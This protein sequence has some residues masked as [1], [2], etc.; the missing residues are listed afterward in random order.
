MKR[1]I[2]VGATSGIGRELA[3][4][5]SQNG[6][7][8]GLTGRREHLLVSLQSELPGPSY[9]QRTDISQPSESIEQL[10]GLAVQ[11]GGL[12]L[13]IISAG[14]GVINSDLAWDGERDKINVNVSGFTAVASFGIRYFI[15]QGVGHL[16]AI[17]SVAAL[18][19]SGAAPAYNASKAFVSNYA[20]GLRQKV[21]KLKL[22]IIITDV[23]PGFVDTAMAKGEGL[24][25]VASPEKAAQ[26]I[27]NAICRQYSHVYVTRRWRVIGWVLKIMPARLY[28]RM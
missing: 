3:K 2:I 11:M 12:D 28:N 17:S 4:I 9:L 5:L 26:Q 23:K 14:T 19:G 25:W 18:R 16:V 13:L 27:Y 6:Y 15:K 24:F 10:E 20:E 21:S 1:A 22:P 7:A 8:V